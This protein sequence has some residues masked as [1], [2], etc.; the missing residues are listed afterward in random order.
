MS[1]NKKHLQ[2]AGPKNTGKHSL[3]KMNFRKFS[4]SFAVC[5]VLKGL[6]SD[7]PRMRGVKSRRYPLTPS[8]YL[9]TPV[10]SCGLGVLVFP[11]A[12]AVA[13]YRSFRLPCSITVRYFSGDI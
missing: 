12:G 7:L 4:A 2:I 5:Q 11:S 13:V 10:L 6:S 8:C 9:S 1:G 3:F